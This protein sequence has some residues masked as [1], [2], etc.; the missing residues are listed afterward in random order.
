MNPVDPLLLVC[1]FR[2]CLGRQTYVV[3]WC[4]EYLVDNWLYID[5]GTKKTI[6]RDLLEAI[7]RDDQD[8]EEGRDHK[9]LGM[10]MDRAEWDR[11]LRYIRSQEDVKNT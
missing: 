7:E 9:W 10:D 2:Y 11:L 4:V 6:A 3:N 8:R 5:P 1:A